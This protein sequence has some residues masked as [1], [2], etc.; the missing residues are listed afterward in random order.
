M[1]G[2]RDIIYY[3]CIGSFQVRFLASIH[4]SSSHLY[5]SRAHLSALVNITNHRPLPI[6]VSM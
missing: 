5:D 2:G 1:G 4:N 3:G 6:Y